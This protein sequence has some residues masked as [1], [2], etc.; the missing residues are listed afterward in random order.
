MQLSKQFEAVPMAK[1][2]LSSVLF[3]FL[4]ACLTTSFVISQPA[5]DS[6]EQEA[7]YRVLE[8]I[9]SDVPWRTLFPDDFCIS[10]PHGVVCDYFSDTTP[11]SAA[12]TPHITE[13][14]FGYVS[15]YSPNPPCN[16]NSTLDPFLFSPLSHLRKLFFYK[17]F[18]Q[19][20]IPFPDFSPLSSQNSSV[21]ELIFIENPAIYGTI[22]GKLSSLRRFVLTGSN[23]SGEIPRGFAEL[24]NL[25]QLSISRNKFEGEIPTNFFQ[26]LKKLKILDLS[27]NGFRGNIPESIGN[28][29]ALMKIDMS[30]NGFS[31]EIPENF[32]GLKG[33]EF[34]DLSYNHFGNFGVPLFLGEMK[35]LKEVYLSGNFLGGQIPEIWENLGGILRIGLSGTGLVGNIPASLG[36][37]LRNVCYLGLDNNKLEGPVPNE[38]ATLEFV[39]EM[40]LENNKLGGRVPFSAGFVSKLGK[41]LKLKGNS[42]LCVDDGLMSSKVS[43][44]LGQLKLCS[45]PDIPKTD[46]FK[47]SSYPRLHVS[48]VLMLIGFLFF[49]S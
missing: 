11:S 12:V 31:G 32:K 48:Y 14:S 7:V 21:E 4:A 33:L 34:L 38:F 46:L 9:N 5:L 39:S 40:N 3:C 18:T 44:S 22:S 29:T 6:A 10:A 30:F 20:E 45:K 25:E 2:M 23:V 19:M 41:K 24:V 13:L 8:S 16:S 36:T 17:C 49:L 43:G 1:F 28:L 42:D 37:Y 47:V 15:D 26:K 27:E 35:S